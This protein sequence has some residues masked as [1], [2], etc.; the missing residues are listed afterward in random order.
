MTAAPR[1]IIVQK[2]GGS[3]VADAEKIRAV[4][5]RICKTRATGADVV[6]TVSA[7]GDATDELIA[8]ANAVVGDQGPP[9]PREMDT[10]LSTGELVSASLMAM[11]IRARGHDVISL[12]GIQ[13]GIKTD[14][15]HGSAR[16][17][18]IDPTRIIRELDAGRVV[19]VAGFQG[20]ADTQDVT[21]LGRGASDTT[22]VALAARLGAARCEIYTDVDGIY[23]T[24]PRIVP[25]ARK[26]AEI[27]YGDMLEMASLGAKMNPRS[28]ELGAVYGVPILVASTFE[29]LP[30]TLI[31]GES[32]RGSTTMEIRNAVTA[33]EV[34]RDVAEVSLRTNESRP[35]TS[36]A[37][38]ERVA[39]RGVNVDVILANDAPGGDASDITFTV[40]SK[41]LAS[42]ISAASEAPNAT[43]ESRS[44][45]AKVS[46]VGT[47]MQ[48]SPG[49]AA[50]MFRTLSSH[51]VNI[52]LMATAEVHIT[53]IV[54]ASAVDEGAAALAREFEA[55]IIES[56]PPPMEAFKYPVTGLAIARSAARITVRGVID[57]P[58][59]AAGIFEPL[60]EAGISVD[61]LVQTAA[62]D[63]R[64]DM[65]FT[66]EEDEAA[67]AKQTV[68]AVTDVEFTE[69]LV[70]AA[71]SKVSVVGA[72]LQS[73]P[74]QA[75]KM[76]R[77]MANSGVNIRSITT[78]DIRIT[79]LVDSDDVPVSARALH[80]AFNLADPR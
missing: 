12:S 55:P 15:R 18:N 57:R 80:A 38:F 54:D 9:D 46:I 48:N 33:V 17:A 35:G 45:L 5:D 28:I 56:V 68:E 69:V 47:G 66:V 59:V 16:I 61:V 41:D 4:A 11:A 2:Y 60:A 14:S 32:L 30:G 22:A 26:L 40:A 1:N 78:A 79:C 39:E 8:L 20:L 70:D 53:C 29:D 62:S 42:A 44:D 49:Y 64:T 58:G 34:E 72:G 71:M 6:V 19:V 63:G 50:R 65:A 76:F 13:A 51:G 27:D 21:T 77:T 73:T 43:V 31:H 36:A 3:S 37:L 52:H 74:G 75:A 10:L 25:E 67:R 23:T 7:M 24:D